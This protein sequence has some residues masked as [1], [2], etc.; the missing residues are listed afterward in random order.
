MSMDLTGMGKA[1]AVAKVANHD[2]KELKKATQGFESIFLK[3]L[4]TELRST[5]KD[6]QFG[7][8]LGKDIYEDMFTQALADSAAKSN[9]LGMGQILYKQFAPRIVDQARQ[10]FEEAT[11]LARTQ[12]KIS[13]ATA[14]EAQSTTQPEAPTS[15]SDTNTE[16]GQPLPSNR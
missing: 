15:D 10:T 7:Q 6:S 4:F 16:E 12:Q 1:M 13:S 3:K 2:L 11:K 5:V 8:G 14:P 9:S